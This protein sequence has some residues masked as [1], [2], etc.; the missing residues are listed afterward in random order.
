MLHRLYAS[1]TGT[2]T[3]A[4]VCS[5]KVQGYCVNMLNWSFLILLSKKVQEFFPICNIFM[6][7]RKD[8][9]GHLLIVGSRLPVGDDHT[10]NLTTPDEHFGQTVGL[11][12]Y[13]VELIGLYS[14]NR[15][16]QEA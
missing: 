3:P 9:S 11:A 10:T 5:L 2:S 13:D 12:K 7:G 16:C 15:H 1:M 6:S 14:A 4:N 8:E